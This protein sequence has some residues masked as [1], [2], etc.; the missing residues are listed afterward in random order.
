MFGEIF[1]FALALI[2]IVFATIQDIK[3]REV[4]NWLNFSLIIFALGFRFFYS[5]FLEKGFSFFYQGLIGFGIFFILGN[6]LYYG[7][8]FA[9]GDAK[10][11]V[12]LGT[13]L[14]FS[15][16]FETNLRIF[17]L[18]FV[19]FLLVGVLY[20]ILFTVYLSIKH[21]RKFKKEF[22][23]QFRKNKKFVFLG[24]FIAI[25]FVIFGFFSNL[26]FLLGILIFIFPYLYIYVKA[27]DESCMVVKIKADKLTEG[28]WLYKNVKIG[29]KTIKASW[30][31]LNKNEISLIKK[32]KDEVLIRKGIP[33]TP[34][35]L[36]SF[37][38]LFYFWKSNIWNKINF[39]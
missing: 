26:F 21:S 39:M 37:I 14:S 10:L 15:N 16:I 11:M 36:I 33:F 12:A 29:N 32:K 9:G 20:S 30:E 6:V 7:K 35:F 24:I 19:L 34:V 5:L 1:L 38:L 4:A 25:I 27:V 17:L 18:F 13:V 3:K 23:N 2:W 22:I 28:D 31:G 8:M